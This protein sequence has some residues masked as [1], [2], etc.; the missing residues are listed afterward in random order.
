MKLLMLRAFWE[1]LKYDLFL[2]RNGFA[3]IHLSV[4]NCPIAESP[5]DAE[6]AERICQAIGW[7]SIWYWKQVMCLQRSVAAARM[8]RT[9]GV[10]AQLVI[11]TRR[12]PFRTHAWVELNGVV[13]NDKPRVQLEYSVL[14]RC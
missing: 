12:L 8:L 11:G 1:L 9:G 13:L 14:E 3:A 2:S 10:P 4:Q 6:D 5:S 7:A